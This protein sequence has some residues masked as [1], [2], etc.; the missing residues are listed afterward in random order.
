MVLTPEQRR[1][2]GYERNGLVDVR[3]FDEGVMLTL[4]AEAHVQGAQSGY[5]LRPDRLPRLAHPV[6]TPQLGAK[7]NPTRGIP[8]IFYNPEDQFAQYTYPMVLVRRTS[9]AR[10]TQR[11]H[12]GQ[13][14]YRTAAVG[15]ESRVVRGRESPTKV[16]VRE[17]AVPYTYD[18]DIV[19]LG[20]QRGVGEA[21]TGQGHQ[22]NALLQYVLRVFEP[23]ALLVVDSVGDRRLYDV[24]AGDPSDAD[25]VYDVGTRTV[26]YVVPITVDGELDLLD[27]Q[28]AP[29]ALS[30]RLSYGVVE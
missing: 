22:I 1:E 4:Q 10:A 24:R 3:S 20:K 29:V 21:P 14:Q 28:V 5:Y 2:L 7:V 23:G 19:V 27:P 15:A 16:E 12:P 6:S 11:L 18:Y 17:Q 13:H 8:V 25:E 9:F 26:G 30:T